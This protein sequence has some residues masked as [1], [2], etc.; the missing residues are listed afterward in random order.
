MSLYYIHYVKWVKY[1]IMSSN[2]DLKILYRSQQVSV[3]ELATLFKILILI[4]KI[5]QTPKTDIYC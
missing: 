5:L 4:F 3:W 1:L 2:L